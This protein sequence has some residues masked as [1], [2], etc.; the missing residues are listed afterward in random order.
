MNLSPGDYLQLEGTHGE[1]RTRVW[2]V[3]TD[4]RPISAEAPLPLKIPLKPLPCTSMCW[5]LAMCHP[6]VLS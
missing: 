5:L 2:R 1:P 6:I 3:Q 4:P